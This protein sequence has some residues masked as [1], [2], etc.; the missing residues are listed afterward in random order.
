[1]STEGKTKKDLRIKSHVYNESNV[2]APNRAMLRAVGFTDE[3]FTKPQ[4]GIAS[5]WAEVTPCNI[6]L[7]DLAPEAKIGAQ[8]AGGVPLQF[9]TITVSDGISTGTQG[10]RCSLPSRGL[11]AASIRARLRAGR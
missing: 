1:M 7:N 10:M 11:L 6:H 3:S 8:E 4:I 9:N 2:K 5:T